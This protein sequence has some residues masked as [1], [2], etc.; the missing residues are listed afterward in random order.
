MSYDK[1]LSENFTHLKNKLETA[2]YILLATAFLLSLYKNS[3]DLQIIFWQLFPGRDFIEHE[4]TLANFSNL[5]PIQVNLNSTMSFH[6]VFH[7]VMKG[8]LKSLEAQYGFYPFVQDK[9]GAN[10]SK[11]IFQFTHGSNQSGSEILIEEAYPECALHFSVKFVKQE[12]NTILK[13]DLQFDNSVISVAAANH[14]SASFFKLVTTITDNEDALIDDLLPPDRLTALLLSLKNIESFHFDKTNS[15]TLSPRSVSES[16]INEWIPLFDET[17]QDATSIYAGW[18]SS[19]TNQGIP[20]IE[21]EEWQQLTAERILALQPQRLLDFGCGT[22]IIGSALLDKLQYYVGMD[23][24][25]AALEYFQN[26]A[27]ANL[28]L[29]HLTQASFVERVTT[30]IDTIVINSV[31]QYFPTVNYFL[32]IL[33]E[34]LKV[35]GSQGKIFLGDIRNFALVDKF[36]HELKHY[37][38]TRKTNNELQI[39]P[40]FFRLLPA[41]FPAFSVVEILEKTGKYNNEMNHYRYD[42]ILHVSD[43]ITNDAPI[44]LKP[45][46]TYTNFISLDLITT[47]WLNDLFSIENVEIKSNHPLLPEAQGVA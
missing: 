26:H 9:L 14:L 22:G 8:S 44:N 4:E 30:P 24:S 23:P 5:I 6:D 13:L 16:D 25:K 2:D 43:T 17:Y 12:L 37:S 29:M 34:C 40:E 10:P 35:I 28:N 36:H 21:M 19:F 31:V 1:H 32:V 7:E 39:H 47:E 11:I 33:T 3:K 18:I 15:L 20:A 45:L 46:E 38:S 41:Y 27:T 42:V